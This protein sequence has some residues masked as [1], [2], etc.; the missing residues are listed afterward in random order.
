MPQSSPEKTVTKRSKRRSR[1]VLKLALQMALRQGFQHDTVDISDGYDGNIH[2]I[3]V[4]RIFEKMGE[5]TRQAYLWKLMEHA[6]LTEAERDLVT[7]VY[8]IS[9]KELV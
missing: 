1:P 8:A 2:V 3:V 9:P 4:S 5:K 6:N 7:L